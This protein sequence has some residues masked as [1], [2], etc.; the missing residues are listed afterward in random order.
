MAIMKKDVNLGLLLLIVA[1]L[2]MFSGFTVY[3]QTTFKN[4]SKSFEIKIKELEGVSKE[5]ESKRGQLNET[6]LQLQLKKQKEDD[7]SKKF[8]ETESERSQ[9]ETDKNKLTAE[10]TSTKSDL[11]ST[12]A[13]LARTKDL[14]TAEIAKS[15]DLNRQVLNLKSDVDKLEKKN[16]CL[17]STAG[18]SETC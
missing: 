5:L 14:L 18:A 1:A 13:D 6:S 4:V 2:L 12:K 3:Y 8:V 11:A 16:D 10:L 7:L 9:L 15:Q 17:K